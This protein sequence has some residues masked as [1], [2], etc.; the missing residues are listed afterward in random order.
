ML[1][2]AFYKAKYGD[3]LDRVIDSCSG[4]GG[5]SHVELVFDDGVCFSSSGRDGGV[6]FKT[7]DIHSGHWDIVPLP[8]VTDAQEAVMR[9]AARAQLGLPY[10]F[11]ACLG[12]IL[13][14]VPRNPNA[15]M[16]SEVCSDVLIAG[17]AMAR[18]P[19]PTWRTSPN[20]LFKLLYPPRPV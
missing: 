20:D 12:F 10:N 4:F 1:Q 19:K 3:W 6:R 18:T 5:H 8:A 14:F 15:R 9:A 13:P 2:V 17:G 7:I 11:N 16:C